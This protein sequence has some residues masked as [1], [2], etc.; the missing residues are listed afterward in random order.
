LLKSQIAAT[1]AVIAVINNP[2]G[3][4][5]TTILKSRMAA[6]AFFVEPVNRA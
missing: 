3:F 1:A 5:F 6:A 4:I 2:I